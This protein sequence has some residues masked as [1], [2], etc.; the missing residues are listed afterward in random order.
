MEPITADLLR[1]IYPLNRLPKA[2][3]DELL[4]HMRAA[5]YSSGRELFDVGESPKDYF[6]VLEGSLWLADA[7]QSQFQTVSPVSEGEAI[8]LPYLVPSLHRA[9]ADSDTKLLLVDRQ[10]LMDILRRYKPQSPHSLE[11]SYRTDVANAM[12]A[13][14]ADAW[15][16][17]FL[18]APGFQRIAP[19]DLKRA[20]EVMKPVTFARG[21]TVVEQGAASDYF[22]VLAEGRVE[23]LRMFIGGR[24]PVRVAE[25]GPGATLGE[26]ALISGKP[27]NAT[28]RMLTDGVLMQMEGDD[29]R[30]LIKRALLRSVKYKEASEMISRGSRWLDV[31]M[32]EER[33]G[34]TLPGSI[35]IPHPIVRARLF[36]ADPDRSYIAVCA[37]G[38]DSAVIAFTLCKYGFDAYYLKDGFRAIPQDQTTRQPDPD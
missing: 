9:R 29:F 23:V 8:P 13:S 3:I 10:K 21:T 7:D 37:T 26:D 16:A 18:R 32:P 25:Y 24:Q 17:A 27:R 1:K 4:P 11:M 6:Y 28:V 12:A 36:S 14:R 2:A 34:G 35:V 15:Q 38:H 5:W 22:Y 31:R 30:F 20:F 33:C 19:H